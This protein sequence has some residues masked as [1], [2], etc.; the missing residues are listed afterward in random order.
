MLRSPAWHPP[1]AGRLPPLEMI[2][3]MGGR[4][5]RLLDL[6]RTFRCRALAVDID[7]G[8]RRGPRDGRRD[9]SQHLRTQENVIGGVYILV[10]R[11]IT[12]KLEDSS[13]HGV[14]SMGHHVMLFCH[15]VWLE[16]APQ[17]WY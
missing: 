6:V 11:I 5:L 12:A 17:R 13:Q 3:P 16:D 9:A 10:C 14:M 4:G 1:N 7:R 15:F 8:E 2:Y